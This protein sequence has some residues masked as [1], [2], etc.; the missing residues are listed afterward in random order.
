[1]PKPFLGWIRFSLVG[2][3]SVLSLWFSLHAYGQSDELQTA[4]QTLLAFKGQLNSWAV[5]SGDILKEANG[6]A[7]SIKAAH[8][9]I[10]REKPQFLIEQA[11]LDALDEN[12]FIYGF[13]LPTLQTFLNDDLLTATAELAEDEF[14]DVIVENEELTSAQGNSIKQKLEEANSIMNFVIDSLLIDELLTKLSSDAAQSASGDC[15]STDDPA[16][17]TS[18]EGALTAALELVQD[19]DNE[20]ADGF[21][22]RARV[23]LREFNREMRQLE[24]K[25]SEILKRIKGVCV[26][27]DRAIASASAEP[28]I[29]RPLARTMP[30]G[31]MQI[32]NLNGK[33]YPL[34]VAKALPSGVYLAVIERRDATGQI[35]SRR[36]QKFILSH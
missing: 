7:V 6:M 2:F 30:E 8:S 3:V 32:L 35:I 24:R 10:V 27:I 19:E 13:K 33:R 20:T 36:L 16:D 17:C 21:L 26:L 23:I 14:I 1:M 15:S 28:I 12:T 25:R 11:I 34:S 29:S 4:S 5:M 9:L 31:T 18:V 22:S